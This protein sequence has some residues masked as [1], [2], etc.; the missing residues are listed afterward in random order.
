MLQKISYIIETPCCNAEQI[1]NKN[2]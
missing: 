2:L 1:C